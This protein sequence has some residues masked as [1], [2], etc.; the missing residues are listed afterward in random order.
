[1]S[2]RT[3]DA[4]VHIDYDDS[5]GT[6]SS[7]YHNLIIADDTLRICTSNPVNS[8]SASGNVGEIR[9]GSETVL[10]ITTY[11]MYLCVAPNTWKRSVFAAY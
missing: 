3:F 8:S 11:Y 2:T 9:W 5:Q 7:G 1:M 4:E 10:L 6:T